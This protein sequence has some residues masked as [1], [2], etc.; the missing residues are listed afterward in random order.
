MVRVAFSVLLT[1]TLLVGRPAGA[2]IY[3]WVDE[4]GV[5]HL[6]DTLENVPESE[7]PDAKVFQSR[8]PVPAPLPAGASTSTQ[9]AF[10]NGIAR[11]LG[12]VTSDTQDPVSALHIVGIYPSA[13][14][15]PAAPL[16]ASV[17]DEL[18]RTAR[19]AARSHRLNQ[20]EGAAEAAVLR[21]S[22]GLGVAG[23][24]PTIVAQPEP[25]A[26]APTVVV[27]PNIYVEAPPANVTVNAIQQAPPPVLTGYGFDAAY[28]NGIPFAPLPPVAGPIPDRITPLS[29]PAG[30]LH[31]PAV[32]PRPRLQ[33]F[34]RPPTF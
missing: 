34:R 27:A 6:D 18:A 21:V 31:G 11:E 24:P 4:H 32:P 2:E 30:H 17:V 9:S 10:A 26:D 28:A 7:R 29:N 1:A 5:T 12:L 3:R 25:A 33:P 15:N 20:S 13:G 19:A 14:W 23:P 16:T 8:A 22:S